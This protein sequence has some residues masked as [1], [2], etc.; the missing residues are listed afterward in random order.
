MTKYKDF[1][2]EFKVNSKISDK[3]NYFSYLKNAKITDTHF[4]PNF[5]KKKDNYYTTEPTERISESYTTGLPTTGLPTTGLPTTGIPTSLL[6]S[7]Q[8]PSSKNIT[9]F[10][11]T[12]KFVNN[13]INNNIN[14]NDLIIALTVSLSGVFFTLFSFM[15]YYNYNLKYKTQ[16]R[17]EQ[18]ERQEKKE[19]E[20]DLSFGLSYVDDI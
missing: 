5:N 3:H 1:V 13:N 16:A 8:C 17:I 7:T 9:T 19:N 20:L 6:H 18:K 10:M 12:I 4:E 15:I 14:N 2:E 11:P